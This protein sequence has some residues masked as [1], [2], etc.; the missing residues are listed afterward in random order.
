MSTQ[1]Y[2]TIEGV[3]QGRL[4]GDAAHENHR[5]KIVGLAFL[6]EVE[7]ARIAPSGRSR[8]ARKHSPVVFVKAW[9]SA[10]TQLFQALTTSEMLK[11]V[12]FEFIRTTA[13]G[14]EEVYHVVR[15]LEASILTIKQE[16]NP[17]K[18]DNFPGYPAIERVALTFQRIEIE[19]KARGTR[20]AD[21]WSAGA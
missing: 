2:V 11:T 15:L 19:N 13:D 1:F 7:V 8:G 9:D 17:S 16:I 4:R 3:R 10:S 6:Y 20:A 21:E 5:E 14:A 18:S 12:T